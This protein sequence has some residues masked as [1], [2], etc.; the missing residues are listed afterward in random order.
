[1]RDLVVVGGGPIG[2]A[3]ALYATRAGLDVVV[4]EPREAPVDKA[5]GEGLMPGAVAELDALGIDLPGHAIAG[6]RYVA[7][8]RSVDAPFTAGPGRGVRRT[9]LHAALSEAAGREGV[10]VERRTVRSLTQDV[11]GVLV[12]GERARY[13]VAADGLHST[14]RRLAGLE[15]SR[16]GRRRYGLR[17]HFAM[18][19]W[20]PFVEVHWSPR[21]EAYVTPV[22]DD[23]VGV[24][25]LVDGGGDYDDLLT[26]FPAL[27]ERLTGA[28]ASRVLGAGPLRQRSRRRVAGRVLLVGDASG[29]VDALTGEGVALGLAQA[30]AAV[31]AVR[32]GDPAPYERTWRQLS[33]RHNALTQGLLATTGRPML[34]RGLVPAAEIL[35]WLFRVA[36]NELARP[37]VEPA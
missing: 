11:D 13:V 22:G 18:A 12:D 6:I 36:V 17:R 24:A 5:C 10:P 8:R 30:R 4:H 26:G 34:R 7:G 37:V 2:L 14:V 16:R 21:A 28:P 19:P 27:A 29:Y 23:C 20:T 25:V 9:A 1:M 33:W 32:S 31:T 15:G 3:T 35:P